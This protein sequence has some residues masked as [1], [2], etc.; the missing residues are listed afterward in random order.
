MANHPWSTFSKKKK[1]S[2]RNAIER[3]YGD[4]IEKAEIAPEKVQTL[5]DEAPVKPKVA[6]EQQEQFKFAHWLRLNKI[7]FY[8]P[9]N[10][11]NRDL[12]EASKLKR[13]GVSPGV[14]DIVIPIA[15][16]PYHSLYIELKRTK[17]GSVSPEQKDWLEW[18]NFNGHRAV[19][20]KGADAAIEIVKQYLGL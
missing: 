7:R 12:I 11:G 13:L 1:I 14:P 6:T 19:I 10:G 5:N 20:C 8:H 3:L 18:L 15:V 2:H 16:E 9:P 4:K 17:G